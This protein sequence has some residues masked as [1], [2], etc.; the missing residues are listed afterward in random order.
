MLLCLNILANLSPDLHNIFWGQFHM[1]LCLNILANL[2]PDLHNIKSLN[3]YMKVVVLSEMPCNPLVP[4]K[5]RKTQGGCQT[6]S[7]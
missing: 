6:K 4:W 7:G 3:L 1:L 2:S 5:Q